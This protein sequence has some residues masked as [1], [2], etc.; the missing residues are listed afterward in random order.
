MDDRLTQNVLFAN[1]EIEMKS[2]RELAKLIDALLE[3]VSV[4]YHGPLHDRTNF[5]A[6]I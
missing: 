2:T 3:D 4:F 1:V 5:L 6:L